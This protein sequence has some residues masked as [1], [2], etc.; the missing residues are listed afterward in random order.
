MMR[1]MIRDMMGDI[2]ESFHATREAVRNRAVDGLI[3]AERADY[4]ETFDMTHHKVVMAH[5]L[6]SS[7]LLEWPDELCSDPGI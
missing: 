3:H 7:V 6:V 2:V 1:N 5:G 4:F